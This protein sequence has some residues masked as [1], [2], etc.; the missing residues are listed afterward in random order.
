MQAFR[1]QSGEAL[2]VCSCLQ[3]GQLPATLGSSKDNKTLVASQP[4]CKADK[5]RSEDCQAQQIRGVSDG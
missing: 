1:L 4:S 3:L 5:D 2:S